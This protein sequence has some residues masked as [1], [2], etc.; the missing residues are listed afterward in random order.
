MDLNPV[1]A[2]P[3]GA[4]VADARVAIDPGE[5]ARAQAH[6]PHMAIHPYPVELEGEIRLRDGR[7]VGFQHGDVKPNNALST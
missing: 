3:G 2:H 6:Y 4:V 7:K 5:P 1:L